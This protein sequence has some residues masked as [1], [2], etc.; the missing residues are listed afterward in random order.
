MAVERKPGSNLGRPAI[1]WQQAF[2]HYACLPPDRRSYAAVAARFEVSVRTVERHGLRECW[3]QRA[4]QIDAEAAAAAAAKLTVDRTRKLV[5]LEKL[6]D[7][8]EVLYAQN[9]RSGDVRI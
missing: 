8:S 4:Y 7:A 5:D 6:I 1:D 9:L 3:K 2:H